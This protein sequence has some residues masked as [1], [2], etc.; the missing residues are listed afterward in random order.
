MVTLLSQIEA[1]GVTGRDLYEALL[2]THIS[3]KSEAEIIEEYVPPYPNKLTRPRCVVRF[4][5]QFLRHSC[6]PKQGFFWDMYGDD[7]Q[8][9]ALALAAILSAPTPLGATFS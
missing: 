7:F 6:G 8:T 4:K 1:L 9:P 3:W 2:P 5:D